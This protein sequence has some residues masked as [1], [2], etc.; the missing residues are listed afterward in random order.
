[1]LMNEFECRCSW[2]NPAAYCNGGALY[3]S[4]THAAVMLGDTPVLCP[5]CE[6]QGHILTKTGE[7]F[8]EMIWR[9]L[10][11]K[12]YAAI[13]EAVDKRDHE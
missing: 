3:D 11:G 7:M 5:A 13:R 12:M 4:H 9:R 8:M 1:M 6:G 10:Q 2:F